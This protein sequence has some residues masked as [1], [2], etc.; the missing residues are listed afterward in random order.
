M[1]VANVDGRT[2]EQMDI[3]TDIQADRK[4]DPY[5]VPC[6]RQGRQKVEKSHVP[7]HRK[8]Y[9]NCASLHKVRY[10]VLPALTCLPSHILDCMFSQKMKFFKLFLAPIEKS[11]N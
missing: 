10:P 8:V 6:L 2:D 4:P 11:C 3:Q 9:N 1:V 5:V 7:Q